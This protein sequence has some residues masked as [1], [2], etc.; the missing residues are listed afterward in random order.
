VFCTC[1]YTDAHR[2]RLEKIFYPEAV[3]TVRGF[4]L[5]L[6]LPVPVPG[7]GFDSVTAARRFKKLNG[8]FVTVSETKVKRPNI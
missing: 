2:L 5:L 6:R 1:P 7:G 8:H 4:L 3:G